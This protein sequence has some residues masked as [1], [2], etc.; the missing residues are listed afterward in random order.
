MN[1]LKKTNVFA[2]FLR[3]KK[4]IDAPLFRGKE[5]RKIMNELL[6]KRILCLLLAAAMTFALAACGENAATEPSAEPQTELHTEAAQTEHAADTG[7][8]EFIEAFD[9]EPV[10][11]EQVVLDAAD[12]KV[13]AKSL[14]YDPING[15]SIDL[16]VENSSAKDILIQC[17]SV[18]VN[19]YM[20]AV[21]F[22]LELAA[23]KN[24]EAAMALPYPSLAMAGISAVAQVEFS[25][26]VIEQT[27]FDKVADSGAVTIITTCAG[28]QPTEDIGGQI[29]YNAKG[30][31][32]VLLGIDES[33]RFS[34][35][36]ALTVYMENNTEKP[37][38]VQTVDVKVNGY[39][40]TSAMTT[41]V[42]PG[43]RAVDIVPFFDMDMQ[44][45][46]I[47][48]IDAAEVSFKILDATVWKPVAETGL[49]VV[50][51][52]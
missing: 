27:S 24:A 46:D 18:A 23:G 50:E 17:D 31:R 52:S 28:V 19:G 5:H 49:I 13:I 47:G 29:A 20:V 9:K 11:D 25:L 44:E 1:Q 30:I 32:I 37:I 48:E 3:L 39:D 14:T 8:M 38:S 36:T 33:R 4:E 43:K 42:L 10:I 2:A 7:I 16:A 12:V 35:S 45:Y 26:R 51:L 41:A 6:Y 21:G 15:P 22:S 34:D 40:F